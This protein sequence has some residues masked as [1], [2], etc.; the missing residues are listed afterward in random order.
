MARM[1]AREAIYEAVKQWV[2]KC[3]VEDRSVFDEQSIYSK[4]RL[5]ELDT[6]YVKNLDESKRDFMTKLEDQL[7]P[8][9]AGSQAPRR[10]TPLGSTPLQFIAQA[11]HQASEDRTRL[12]LVGLFLPRI[13]HLIEPRH[14]RGYR[15]DR[16][17][18]PESFLARV[19]LHHQG[20]GRH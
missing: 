10:R 11:G 9:L 8:D 4:S 12:G 6:H 13:Q 20:C 3:L 19:L 14:A 2:E 1:K 5:D 17:R 18:L 16:T 7:A 15:R